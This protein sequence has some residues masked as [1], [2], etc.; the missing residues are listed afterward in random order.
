MKQNGNYIDPARLT[1]IRGKGVTGSDLAAFKAEV[2][3]LDALLAGISIDAAPP[4]V[5]PT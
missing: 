4:N 1:P 5:D 3:R 2:A